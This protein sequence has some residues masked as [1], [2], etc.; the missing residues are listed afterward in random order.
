MVSMIIFVA[1]R[2]SGDVAILLAPQDASDEEIH[3]IRIQLGLDKPIYYQYYIFVKNAIKGDFGRS[4]RYNRP[5]MD[6]LIDR[7][8]GSLEL[9]GT[10]FLLSIVTGV[11]LG[12]LS[13]TKRGTWLDQSG[14]LFALFGQSMPGFWVGIMLILIFSVSLGWLPTSGRGGLDHLLLPAFSMAWYSIASIMRV[15]RSSMM[16]VMDTDYIKM[17][18]AKGNSE[19]IIIWKH[20]LK[21]A[22]IP[23]I[24]L[25]GVQ[26]A[27]LLGGAVII[28]SVFNWPGLGSLIVDAIYARDYPLVQ[29]GVFFISIFL[30]TL[31]LIVDLLFGFIDPRIRYE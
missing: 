13:A 15:T 8:F 27:N 19:H 23:V 5:A 7:L 14:R 16:D 1:A 17:A 22:L 25:A 10:A 21:N 6:V 2:L 30:I 28:E 3:A 9:V 26:L 4:I 18:R 11:L 20:G 31:N 24:A 29:A 12:T